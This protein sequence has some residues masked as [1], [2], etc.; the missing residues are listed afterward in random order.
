MNTFRI[1]VFFESNGMK[2]RLVFVVNSLDSFESHRFPIAVSALKEGYDVF[3]IYGESRTAKLSQFVSIGIKLIKVSGR[4]GSTNIFLEVIY[5]LELFSIVR[6]L[7]PDLIHLITLKPIL[8]GG[9]AAWF[10]SVPALVIAVTGMGSIIIKRSLIA[11]AFKALIR[12]ALRIV[13][14]HS[15]HTIIVQNIDDKADLI[16]WGV[17]KSKNVRLIAGS[18][19]D[20]S[21][22]C[23]TDEHDAIPVVTFLGRLIKDKGFSEFVDAVRILRNRGILARF[24]VVGSPDYE[25]PTSVSKNELEKLSDENVVELLGYRENVT[26]IYNETNIVC[27]PSYREGLPKS[28]IEAAACGR[29]IVTTDVP[30]CRDAITPDVTGFLVPAKSPNALADKIQTLIENPDLR[31]QMGGA[32]RA[33]A[34]KNFAI[35]KIVSQHL[36]IYEDLQNQ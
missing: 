31:K 6:N 10:C 30:G 12:S 9:I 14:L 13:T 20:L 18:G 2:R 27:L 15:N 21:Q 8:Y 5:A 3:I 28:L 35:E 24:W 33:L 34:E 36:A 25:N 32:G 1:L 4:R 7:K 11:S 29:A 26:E 16:A 23:M 17:A 22:F 19:V